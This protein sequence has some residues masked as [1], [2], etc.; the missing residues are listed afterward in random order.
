MNLK[1]IR[2][3]IWQID[4]TP[5]ILEHRV[6]GLP[7]WLIMRYDLY[8]F[9]LRKSFFPE[10]TESKFSFSEKIRNRFLLYLH[11]Y[12]SRKHNPL[13]I[14]KKFG[15]VN[16]ASGVG[17]IMQKG[18]YISRVSGFLNTIPGLTTL[19]VIYQNKLK[20]PEKYCG[21]YSFLDQLIFQGQKKN[22]YLPG[23][24]V[25]EFRDLF[26][27]VQKISDGILTNKEADLYL[28]NIRIIANLLPQYEKNIRQFLNVVQ[29]KLIIVE[30]ANYGG[31]QVMQLIKI[32][33]EMKIPTAEIQHGI[34]DIAYQYGEQLKNEPAF[35]S[36]KTNYVLT[37]GQYFSNYISSSSENICLG[38]FYLER[39]KKNFKIKSEQGIKNILFISQQAY[40]DVIVPVLEEALRKYTIPFKLIIRLHPSETTNKSRFQKLLKFKFSFFS[41]REDIYDLLL[42]ADFVIGLHS[43]VLF[44]S[45]YFNKVP[46]VYK[47]E[48]S[49]EF[50][51]SSLGR[52]FSTP[53]ELLNLLNNDGKTNEISREQKEMFWTDGCEANF[54][55][56]FEQHIMTEN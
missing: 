26:N 11:R 54:K 37:F 29:P 22:S 33:R 3:Y 32:A 12:H 16:F 27:K 51:P 18:C 8:Q 39:K 13:A 44:E 38:N 15:C 28:N 48:I 24:Q 25:K 56:F 45:I 5:G 52:R 1:D 46:F 55:R 31:W 20:R 35:A 21:V 50:L 14:R 7:L 4:N 42:D 6:N 47:N 17:S 41:H 19:N 2:E 53:E 34:L 49:D 36:C 30:D 40:T 10:H 9:L 43:A 23:E